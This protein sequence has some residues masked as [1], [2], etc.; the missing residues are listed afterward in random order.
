MPRPFSYG[1]TRTW[2]RTGERGETIVLSELEIDFELSKD[3]CCPR[4]GTFI[5]G[6]DDAGTI[7]WDQLLDR[8]GH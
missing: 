5:N 6:A 1:M 4:C 2:E 3:D 7:C 8:M